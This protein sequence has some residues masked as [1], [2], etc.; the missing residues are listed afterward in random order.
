MRSQRLDRRALARAGIFLLIGV[1]INVLVA[2]GCAVLVPI[3]HVSSGYWNA[4][5][6]VIALRPGAFRK[7]NPY[8][9]YP[10]EILQEPGD[11]V[12]PR[13]VSVYSTEQI[14]DQR[15]WPW[16]S[17][18]MEIWE[19]RW[20]S[21]T[22]S[23]IAMDPDLVIDPGRGCASIGLSDTD[24][25]DREFWSQ[26]TFQR[27]FLLIPLSP[28]W[29]GFIGNSLFYAFGLYAIVHLRGEARRHL[30]RRAGRC[31]NCNY[32]LRATTTGICPECGAAITPRAKA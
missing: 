28:V 27:K 15:G 1:L 22:N 31:P 18:E 29:P 3:D 4:I 14:R 11:A 30:R 24:R 19:G 9:P 26:A 25:V 8:L 21:P 13:R 2:W 10:P 17:L 16:Q 20:G 7:V 5:G 12:L 32:D 23:N 6:E